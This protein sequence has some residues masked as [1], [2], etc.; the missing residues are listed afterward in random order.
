MNQGDNI[1][2]MF[3]Q[4]FLQTNYQSKKKHTM[5]SARIWT[6]LSPKWLDFK[7]RDR[8]V[9][10]KRKKNIFNSFFISFFP[11]PFLQ[12]KTN[13]LFCYLKRPFTSPPEIYTHVDKF[14]K[15]TTFFC[16]IFFVFDNRKN[17]LRESY[18]FWNESDFFFRQKKNKICDHLFG[19]PH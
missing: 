6:Q 4:L 19:H 9:Q 14:T 8:N 12:S 1:F 18:I 17:F 5:L 7:S 10:T 2:N 16:T 15:N 11:S 13:T 3:L